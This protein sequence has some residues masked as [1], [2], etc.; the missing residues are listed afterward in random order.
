MQDTHPANDFPCSVLLADGT[1]SPLLDLWRR[2]GALSN[3]KHEDVL[4]LTEIATQ[5]LHALRLTRCRKGG[6]RQLMGFVVSGERPG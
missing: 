3:S 4:I 6:A 2:S 1:A 5:W